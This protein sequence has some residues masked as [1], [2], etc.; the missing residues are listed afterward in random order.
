[1]SQGDSVDVF[2]Q[3]IGKGFQGVIKRH[4]FSGGKRTHGDQVGRAPGSIGFMTGNGRVMKG[5]K[6][7]GHMGDRKTVMKNLEIVKL[8][9]GSHVV[10]VKGSVPGKYGSLVFVRRSR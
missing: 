9:S 7:P 10:F 3:T 6:L 1:M 4:G 5:K 2:G 8:E